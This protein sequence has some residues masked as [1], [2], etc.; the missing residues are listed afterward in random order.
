M[1]PKAPIG[2]QLYAVRGECARSIPETL[3]AVARIGYQ[4]AEPW[5]YS[6]DAVAWQG[7]TGV[8]LRKVFDDTGLRCCGMHL[9]TVA[10]QGD[11]L[12][13]TIELNQLLGNRFLVVAGDQARMSSIAGIAALAG[14]LNGAAAQLK[15]LG[16]FAG[17]HAHPFDFVEVEGEQSWYR[18]FRQAAPEVIMQ[19]DIGNCA[20]GNGDPVK[21]LRTFPG[22]ARSVHLKDYGKPGAV[23]GEGVADWPTIFRLCDTTQPVEWY[24][25]EE[26][27]PDGLGFD[28]PARSLAGLKKMGRI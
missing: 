28:I 1:T 9:N 15:P 21:V 19:L 13:R 6:G 16:L 3:K 25:V 11:N 23:I 2:L 7:W 10:L 20:G 27:G 8:D 24:V 14:I 22:K 5:G 26:C 12:A 18:L 17:Y 4:G